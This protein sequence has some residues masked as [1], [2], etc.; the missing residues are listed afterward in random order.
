M[1]VDIYI[2]TNL[3]V[4]PIYISICMS[5]Y[6]SICLPLYLPTYIYLPF[7]YLSTYISIYLYLSTIYRSVCLPIYLSVYLSVCLSVYLSVYLYIYLS[8]FPSWTR[9]NSSTCWRA[10]TRLPRMRG[11]HR[12]NSCTSGWKKRGARS[13]KPDIGMWES[14]RERETEREREMGE[15]DRNCALY[16]SA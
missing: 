14:E 16:C 12:W 9:K 15:V 4:L 7:I 8:G 1:Y 13:R 5:G 6:V 10:G 2:Y 3:A 11:P